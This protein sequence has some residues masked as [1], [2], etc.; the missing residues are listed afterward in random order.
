VAFRD[1]EGLA[2]AFTREIGRQF[3]EGIPIGANRIYLERLA[4]SDGDG[5]IARVRCWAH[6]FY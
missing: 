4:L 5:P 2:R 3:G 6:Q 1:A